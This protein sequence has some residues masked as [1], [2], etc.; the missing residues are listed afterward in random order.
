MALNLIQVHAAAALA[1]VLV[2][3]WKYVVIRRGLHRARRRRAVKGL[4][5]ALA[6]LVLVAVASGLLHSTGHLEY[7]GPLTLMQVH[8]GA[9]VAAIAVLVAHVL[10]HAVRPRRA[11]A[12]RRALLRWPRSARA[13]W[14]PP[15]RG[16][17]RRPGPGPRLARHR[18]GRRA[19]SVRQ[20]LSGADRRTG[21]RGFWWV[22]WVSAIEPS[23]RPPW[24]QP[25]FPLT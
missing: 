13:P 7:L 6:V 17:V 4:S 5:I 3:P 12:D 22:K 10:A 14:S 21:R 18:G 2:A 1:I 16:L 15:P 25:L 9:A 11:D 23:S 20:R 24:T 19:A 8:V